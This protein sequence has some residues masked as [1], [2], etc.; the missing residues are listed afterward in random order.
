MRRV[1]TQF[2]L[3]L[4][5]M[6]SAGAVAGVLWQWWWTPPSGYVV[7]HQ[8]YPDGAGLRDDFAG[9][10]LYVAVGAVTGL[11]VASLV[12]IL[13]DRSELVALVAVV[14]GSVLAGWVMYRVGLA[15]GPPDPARA[16]ATAADGTTLPGKL[17]VA[18]RSP[19]LAFPIG[20]AL[21]LLLVF[22]GLTRR[23]RPLS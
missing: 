13:L 4:L 11:V 2:S 23:D 18:G 17:T 21:G 5:A 9:A 14:V 19:F 10:G 1:A 6:A 15:L 7:E 3:V 22:F 8:W 16:A 12:A 20:S